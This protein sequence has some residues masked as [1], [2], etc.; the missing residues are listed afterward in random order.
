[1]LK[2]CIFLIII[3]VLGIACSE[4]QARRPISVK[5]GN[6]F[7]KESAEK[8]KKLLNSEEALIDSII[9]K[10]TLHNFIDSQH[11]F[12]FYY[13]QQ[14]PEATYTAQ[15]GDKVTY[16]YSISDINGNEIYEESKE[17][18]YQ[19]FVEKEELFLGLRS[20][21]KILKEGE[22]GVF[23][24]P[25][26]IAYGYRGDKDKIESNQPII[27]KIRVTKIEKNNNTQE[28][29]NNQKDTIQKSN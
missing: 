24:F 9:K 6:T 4:K 13:T 27:A 5:S 25:S 11:G 2:K 20:A 29:N 23:F 15:F 14:N 8:N 26:E 3:A 28:I 21:L 22:S 1:M 10:D 7:L 12:K 18:D 16:N 19:Y 17:I